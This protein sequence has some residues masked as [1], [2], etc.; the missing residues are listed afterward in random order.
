[1]NTGMNGPGMV[2]LGAIILLSVPIIL[3]FVFITANRTHRQRLAEWRQLPTLGEYLAEHPDC[4]TD[5]GPACSQCHTTNLINRGLSSPDSKQR[6]LTCDSC[7][8]PLFR[9]G[10]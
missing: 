4:K 9:A 7:N 10:A 5:Q 2:V 8:T 6:I 3:A 1:M